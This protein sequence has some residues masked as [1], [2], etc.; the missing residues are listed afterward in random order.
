MICT[1]G[2][3]VPG[4][5]FKARLQLQQPKLD[6]TGVTL[7]GTPLLI[8]GSNGQIAWGY[9]NSTADWLDVIKLQPGSQT[10][11]YQIPGG[12]KE[13]S[14]NN[15]VIKVKGQPDHVMLIKETQWGPGAG[16]AVP[17][18]RPALGGA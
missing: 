9:T 7:P 1:L 3:R 6:I 10:Q 17:T 18:V 12:E 11:Y 14:Y 5:W 16:P 15:E 8:A 13:Y 4:I 2:M